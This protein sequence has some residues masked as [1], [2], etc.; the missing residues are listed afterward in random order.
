MANLPTGTVT[1][2]FTDIEGSTRLLSHLGDAYEDTLATHRSLLR[3]AFSSHAG[4]EVDTQGD[5][6]FYAFA[7]AR[8]ALQA[9]AA[10]QR[11]ITNHAWPHDAPLRVRMGIH[12]GE[13]AVTQEGYVGADVHL[14][15]R[16]C[17]AAHGAQV[18]VSD[19]TAHL[20]SPH[21]EGLSLRPLGEHRLKDIDH[22][23][24]LHQ[25]IG[26][27]LEADFP[28][29]RTPAATHPTNL[30]ARLQ[31]LI[32]RDQDLANLI[33]LLGTDDVS[34]V[35]LTGPGGTGKTR[36]ALATGQRLLSSFP[37][38]VFFIDLS[39][40]TDPDLVVPAIA[41]AL[42]LRE[43]AGRSLTETL[44]EHLSSKEMLLIVDNL[45]QVIDAATDIAS[46]LTAAPRLKVLATSRE[47]LR[48]TGERVFLLSPLEV[49]SQNQQDLEE[50]GRYPA[51]GLFLVRARAVNA[52]FSLTPDNAAD[53]AAICRRLDGL[54]L[55][56]ELAAARVNLLP[57]SS[58]LSRLDRG[59]KV[60]TSGRRD[61]A[62]RQRTLRGAIEWSYD[63]LAQEEQRL[64]R[65]LGV[66]AGGFSLEAAE[67]VCDRG[68]LDIDVLDGLA[69]LVG[70]SLVRAL[71]E[72]QERFSMLE[73]I[74]EFAAE[75]LEMSGEGDDIRRAHTK[76]FAD[77]GSETSPALVGRYQ[78]PALAQLEVEDAN[79]K[80]ALEWAMTADPPLA[81]RIA[82][83]VWRSW[84][85]RGQLT[86]ARAW[87]ERTTASASA[88][89]SLLG[90]ALR[91]LSAVARAQGDF[92][93]A[94]E[95]AEHSAALFR[96]MEDEI[97]LAAALV[98]LAN[99]AVSQGDLRS[100]T[101][102]SEESRDLYAKSDDALGVAS[103]LGNLGYIALLEK[104]LDDSLKYSQDSVRVCEEEGD[105]EGSGV[106]LLNMGHA[107][108]ASERVDE[109]STMFERAHA[110][111][112]ELDYAELIWGALLGL[113]G[114]ACREADFSRAAAL[115]EEADR[116][117][118]AAMT[119]PE[120]FE[121]ELY[122]HLRFELARVADP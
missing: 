36:L 22:P 53:I 16:I 26:E 77:L 81:L 66:F 76:W 90:R 121:E 84:W 68:D 61:A 39:A 88:P 117:R 27:G 107:L 5:A 24:A 7:R 75:R 83:D 112:T 62:T 96:D 103:S 64:F 57:P 52:D 65:R 17:A 94:R 9:A 110:L 23:V 30:P 73:T 122:E 63:L 6:L 42:S 109:A 104:R 11:A 4:I 34:L 21:L 70:K 72:Q 10:A 102:F 8:D 37:D 108:L 99:V 115:L 80:R 15:A 13:P 85:L 100:A 106:A 49:P 60:L 67:Q 41:Q 50:L 79:M 111:A 87:L 71:E 28:P 19:A 1:L 97:E 116:M 35:T 98:A 59:L 86:E 51:V 3:E 25:L 46:L 114:V 92:V 91:G 31:P 82:S 44:T 43:A 113:A 95:A 14:A 2:V 18:L 69:S 74:R 120:P 29:L 32:G 12:S 101:R 54:P 89:N 105:K 93:V 48:V 78:V 40:I 47:P 119:S 20:L 56:I 45:E 33:E 55:A 58:L 118:D 38:G